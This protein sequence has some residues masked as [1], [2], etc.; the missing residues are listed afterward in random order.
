MTTNL[1]T[2]GGTAVSYT[3]LCKISKERITALCC[4]NMFG[5]KKQLLVI[6]KAKSSRSFK[7]VNDLPVDNDG[8]SN[9]WKMASIFNESLIKRDYV[10]DLV[11]LL[12]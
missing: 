9:A 10:F 12:Y 8:N 11:Q 1:T 3:H 4:G 5:N 2:S 6:G 7:R